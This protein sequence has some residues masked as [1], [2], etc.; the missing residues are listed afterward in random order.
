MTKLD[1]LIVAAHPDDAEISVGGTISRLI[2]AGHAVGVLDVT[3]GELGS[4]GTRADRDAETSVASQALGLTWRGNLEQPDGRVEATV[5]A[6]EELARVIRHLQPDVL[7]AHHELDPHPD[8]VA[9]GRMAREAWY[10]SGLR[11][12]AERVGGAPARRPARLARFMSHRGFAP[13]FVV[14]ITEVWEAKLAA[15]KA[16]ASQLRPEDDQDDGK[17][18]LYRS[19][20][21]ERV[22]TKA[23]AWGEAIGVDYGEPLLCEEPLGFADPLLRLLA[24]TPPRT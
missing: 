7:L 1:V 23:R 8:H 12:L 10:L 18:F 16:Y 3:R 15:V 22:E 5:E 17:H 2:R 6:R 9:S 14:D 11:R 20:I 19:D 13:T 4:R 24:P 21:L